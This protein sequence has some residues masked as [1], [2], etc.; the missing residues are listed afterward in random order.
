MPAHLVDAPLPPSRELG[1]SAVIPPPGP[2]SA[3][4]RLFQKP[5]GRETAS[6]RSGGV[7]RLLEELGIR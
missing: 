2:Q 4:T 7:D 5:R 3:V 6:A 1:N